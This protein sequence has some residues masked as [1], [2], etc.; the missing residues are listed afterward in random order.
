MSII[1]ILPLCCTLY[2]NN[3]DEDEKADIFNQAQAKAMRYFNFFM[4]EVLKKR[5]QEEILKYGLKIK[6][7]PSPCSSPAGITVLNDIIFV[8]DTQKTRLYQLDDN[9]QLINTIELT[10]IVPRGLT[11]F[12][13][14]LWITDETE[15]VYQVGLDGT[16]EGQFYLENRHL[17]AITADEKELLCYD[18]SSGEVISYTTTSGLTEVKHQ[19]SEEDILGLGFISGLLLLDQ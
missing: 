3:L 6:F 19:V 5:N 18:T 8:A 9:L 15:K 13:D 7:F 10:G 2:W 12:E 16:L 4:N 11:A 17:Q 14:Y 1:S